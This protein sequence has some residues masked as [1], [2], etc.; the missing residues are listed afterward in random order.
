MALVALGIMT[1]LLAQTARAEIYAEIYGGLVHGVVHPEYSLFS[2]PEAGYNVQVAIKGIYEPHFQGGLKLGTWFVPE[3]TLGFRYP[4]WMKYFGFYL[5]FSF[6]RLNYVRSWRGVYIHNLAN[7]FPVGSAGLAFHS[8]GTAA[9]LAFMFAG[10]LPILKSTD[11]P[12][13]RL[14]PYLAVG[15]AL[16]FTS[17]HPELHFMH[18]ML[19]TLSYHPNGDSTLAPALA[20]ETGVRWLALKNV[21]VDLSFKYRYARPDFTFNF[22][23]PATGFVHGF[24]LRP[25]YHLL[26]GQLGVAYHF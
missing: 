19:G 12:Y 23:D 1:A 11:F 22:R 20:V 4:N 5:D 16:L 24:S 18:G 26:S 14:Q 17:Q 9:T 3:G 6:H 13:G 25:T 8:E 7:T 2:R 10:R 15:P 21:S